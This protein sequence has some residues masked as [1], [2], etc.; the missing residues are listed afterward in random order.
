VEKMSPREYEANEDAILD[1]MRNGSFEY[2]ISG[3]AR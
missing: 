1:S 2:D 3:G